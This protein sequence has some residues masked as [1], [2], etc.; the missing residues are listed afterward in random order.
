[1]KK[2]YIES[3]LGMFDTF[4]WYAKTAKDALKIYDERRYIGE[5]IT[6]F[7]GDKE[8]TFDELKKLAKGE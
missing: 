1:M 2:F 6:I 8:T 5:F 7:Y 4:G 3:G